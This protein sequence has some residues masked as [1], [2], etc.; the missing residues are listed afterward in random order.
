MLDYEIDFTKFSAKVEECEEVNNN[1]DNTLKD[2]YVM[3]IENDIRENIR[4][5]GFDIARIKVFVDKDYENI[6][7]IEIE[8]LKL[9]DTQDK[10][11]NIANYE[12]IKECIS[13]NYNIKKDII[14]IK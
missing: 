10:E 1:F 11:N 8:G 14:I 13:K 9:I 3:G 5:N 6:E 7:K 4:E 12:I 2:V